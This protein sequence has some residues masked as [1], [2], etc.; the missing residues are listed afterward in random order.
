[1][2]LIPQNHDF[3]WN[4][5]EERDKIRCFTGRGRGLMSDRI[6]S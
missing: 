5:A 2:D 1:M 6:L 4:L 3:F